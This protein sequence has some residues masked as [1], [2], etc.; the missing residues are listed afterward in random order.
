[1]R[2]LWNEMW[3]VPLIDEKRTLAMGNGFR[4][5]KVEKEAE[6]VN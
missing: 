4:R 1:M 3:M 5:Q 2:D 6:E